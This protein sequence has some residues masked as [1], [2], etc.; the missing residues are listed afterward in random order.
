MRVVL[1]QK[2]NMGIQASLSTVRRTLGALL[3]KELLL[4]PGARGQGL[5]GADYTNY[6]FERESEERLTNWMQDNLQAGFCEGLQYRAREQELLRKIE[7]ILNLTG[8]DNP[9]RNCIRNLR[10]A[11][12]DEVRGL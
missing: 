12:A 6:K 5:R 11:C 1:T 2:T 7:P 10:K 4:K 9:H 8:W 3:K